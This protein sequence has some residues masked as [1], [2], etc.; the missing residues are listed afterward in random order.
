MAKK[1]T[2]TKKKVTKKKTAK[3]KVAAKNKK[4]TKARNPRVTPVIPPTISEETLQST[5]E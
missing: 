1:K 2:T 3:K 5:N 4:A